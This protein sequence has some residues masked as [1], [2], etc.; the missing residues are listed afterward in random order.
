VTHKS[1][2]AGGAGV[3]VGI[4]SVE[5]VRTAASRILKEAESAGIDAN[6]LVEEF[7]ETESGTELIVGGV[8]DSSF[9]PVVLVGLGGVFTELY[10]DTVQRLAPVTVEEAKAATE[11][12]TAARLLEGYRGREKADIEAAAEIVATIGEILIEYESIAEIDVNPVLA[13]GTEVIA[14]DGLIV[15]SDPGAGAAG[16]ST[17]PEEAE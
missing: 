7:H 8:R 10:E 17:K 13:T 11:E 2:W 5:A 9:G 1:D 4:D 6:I 3:V 15:L 16:T 14:L 12:L